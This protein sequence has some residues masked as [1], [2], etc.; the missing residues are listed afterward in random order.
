MEE[1]GSASEGPVP[2]RSRRS[3]FLR[4]SLLVAL[5][6]KRARLVRF[7]LLCRRG[8]G[9]GC[10]WCC[11]CGLRFE[12][13]LRRTNDVATRGGSDHLLLE[14]FGHAFDLGKLFFDRVRVEDGALD[15]HSLTL[16]MPRA[17]NQSY[18]FEGERCEA[19]KRRLSRK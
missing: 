10:F 17:T 3:H 4:P 9:G 15:G 16:P 1:D 12:L 13:A 6:S 18:A 5:G 19:W 7:P 11:C 2:R 8:G 14:S